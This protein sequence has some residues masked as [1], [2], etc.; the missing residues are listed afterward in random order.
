MPKKLFK[1]ANRFVVRY[2]QTDSYILPKSWV[3]YDQL[4]IVWHEAQIQAVWNMNVWICYTMPRKNR[5]KIYVTTQDVYYNRCVSTSL[6]SK[7]ISIVC[8]RA[9]ACVFRSFPQKDSKKF[10]NKHHKNQSFTIDT[11]I[12]KTPKIS[13]WKQSIDTNDNLMINFLQKGKVVPNANLTWY[14][15]N[16]RTILGCKA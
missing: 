11:S 7:K 14:K 8:T 13:K 15:T 9:R 16:S 10:S 6:F 3:W 4:Q 5:E 2:R 12:L 1:V